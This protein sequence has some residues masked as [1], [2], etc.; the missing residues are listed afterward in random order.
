MPAQRIKV[1]VAELLSKVEASRAK[2]VKDYDAA[3]AE[4]LAKKKRIRA[5]A[6][7]AL[8]AEGKR[9]RAGGDPV[10]SSDYR[11]KVTIALP[12]LS[13]EDLPSNPSK[14]GLS[15]YDRDIALLKMSADSTISISTDSNWGRYL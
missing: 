14:P 7:R 10:L 3:K 12:T 9:I 4:Y 5:E 11:G 2:A 6:S 13:G 1:S 8:S 15:S